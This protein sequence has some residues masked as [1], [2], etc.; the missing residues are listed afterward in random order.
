MYIGDDFKTKMLATMTHSSH[1][2]T[3]LGHFGQYDIRLK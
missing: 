3:C 2:C 1:Y